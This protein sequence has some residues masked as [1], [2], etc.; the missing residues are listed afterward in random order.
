MRQHVLLKKEI[1]NMWVRITSFTP[2][3]GRVDDLRK[4]Y[5]ENLVPVIKSQPG[6]IDAFLLE[7][8]DGQGEFISLTM[9][10]DRESAEAY[11]SAGTYGKL[12]GHVSQLFEGPPTLRSYE[13]KD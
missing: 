11:D 4:T 3:P 1:K 12:V 8:A 2:Q 5:R 6:G 9:W 7:P 13:V 10:K